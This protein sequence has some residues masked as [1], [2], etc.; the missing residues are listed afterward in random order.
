M[1]LIGAVTLAAA[2]AVGCGN[3]SQG[4]GD[5]C[6]PSASTRY[7]PLQEGATWT[8]KITD[9]ATGEVKEK[10]STVGALE[11]VGGMKKGTMAFRVTTEHLNDSTV[12]WQADTGSAIVRHREQGLDSAGSVTSDEFYDPWKTRI[13]ESRVTVGDSW[14]ESYT[15]IAVGEKAPVEKSETWTVEAVDTEVKVP[16]GTFN[17]LLVRRVSMGETG[18]G[19]DKRYWF[20]K[21]IGK[22][23]EMGG[24]TEELVSCSLP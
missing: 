17:A 5:G 21:G 1:R 19:S 24:Q 14:T 9:P 18:G 11:D 2:L 4:N 6:E 13:D 22:V 20:V 15:E 3:E 7:F 8:Y 12:S 10:S 16:A 23:K